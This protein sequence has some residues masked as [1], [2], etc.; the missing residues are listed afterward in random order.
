VLKE[1]EKY[2]EKAIML[3]PNS[4]EYLNELGSQK[5]AQEKTKDAVKCYNNTLKI[6]DTNSIAML[7]KLRAQIIEEKIDDIGQQFELLSEAFANINT[8]PVN[9]N[10]LMN[11]T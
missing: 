9:R 2:M 10:K 1:T 6:D 11:L 8:Y 3:N 5:L 4:V 7:G